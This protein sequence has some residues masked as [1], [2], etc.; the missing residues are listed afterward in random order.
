[1][2]KNL[3]IAQKGT[4]EHVLSSQ[5][6]STTSW[7]LQHT[8]F[9]LP[10]GSCLFSPIQMA[11][12]GDPSEI[13]L[14]TA[15]KQTLRDWKAIVKNLSHHPT[16]VRLL[17]SGYP[18]YLEYTDACCLG[19]GGAI[20]PGLASI[21]HFIWTFEWPKGIRDAFDSHSITINDLELAALVIGWLVLEQVAPLKFKH[22]VLFC[23]NTSAT[24]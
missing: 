7:K 13:R 21:P 5:K 23:D 3:Q 24:A 8:S 10:G 2:R 16:P 18:H 17:V 11:M 12:L 4:E 20:T 14:T 6:V 19:A 9:G 15:L 1:M 22:V